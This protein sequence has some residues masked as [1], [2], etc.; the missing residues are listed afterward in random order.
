MNINE[1]SNS[2]EASKS[3][4]LGRMSEP[5]F[6]DSDRG[7]YV[8]KSKIYKIP[9]F[10]DLDNL[11]NRNMA[12]LG[13]SGAGKSYF[14]K[15]FVIRSALQRNSYV[16]IIDWNGE[17]N[18]VIEFLGGKNLILGT[19]FKV[20][21]FKLYDLKSIKNIKIVSDC[22]VLSLNLNEEES[23]IIYNKIL[24]MC[25]PNSVIKN[26]SEL[27]TG[28]K[29]DTNPDSEKLANKLL[30]LKENPMFAEGT[31][32]AV[33]EILDGIINID[34][35][36]L[37]DNVQRNDI[38]RSIFMIIIELMH[39]TKIEAKKEKLIIL[40]EAWRLIKNSNDVGVLYREGRKYGFCIIT[41]TQLVQDIDNEVISNAASIVIFRLQNEADYSLLLNSG[42]IREEDKKIIMQLQTGGCMFSIAFKNDNNQICK[43]FIESTDGIST[44]FYNI[45]SGKMRRRISHRLLMESTSKLNASNEIKERLI[46]FISE[47]N[48][49]LDDVH[50]VAFMVNAGI[51]RLEIV[52]YLRLL[53]LKDEHIVMAYNSAVRI[54]KT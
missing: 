52:Y 45:K 3:I 2:K 21:V 39:N 1:N 17:Y 28:F 48:R 35:S 14:L 36:M 10:L 9:F 26:L 54:S 8:G 42:I 49:E 46:G 32:F 5:Y 25:Y 50:L 22:I 51:P 6:T 24:S 41:A 23:Y 44:S 7:I 18:S 13:M 15:S 16:L 43:F 11:I 27:I 19:D 53:G 40:D 31:D 38:S 47:N 33:D 20:N 29:N 37:K 30:Q 4:Y 34:F 12:I